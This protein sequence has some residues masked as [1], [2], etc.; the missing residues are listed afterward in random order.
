VIPVNVVSVIANFS[1]LSHAN[2]AVAP[3]IFEITIWQSMHRLELVVVLPQ[4]PCGFG[5]AV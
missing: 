3:A 2:G 4:E 1:P 5:H